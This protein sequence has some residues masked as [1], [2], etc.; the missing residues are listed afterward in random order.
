MRRQP[1][2]EG[3]QSIITAFLVALVA[4]IGLNSFVVINPGQAGVISIL[5]KAQDEPFLEGLHFKPP[6]I[7]EV[8]VYDVTVQKFEVFAGTK[9]ANI[10]IGE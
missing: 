5:G 4:I 9:K 6:L 3:L 10:K 7:S 1:Q 2:A 8:D